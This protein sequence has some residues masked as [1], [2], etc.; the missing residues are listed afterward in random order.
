MKQLVLPVCL[1]VLV[2]SGAA[3]APIA[4]VPP[5]EP[6][7]G[8]ATTNDNDGYSGGR[9]IGFSVSALFEIHSVGVWHDLTNVALSYGL[10]EISALSGTFTKEAALRSGSAVVS[11]SG[12]EWIDFSFAPVQLRPRVNYLIEFSHTAQGNQNFFYGNN[13]QRWSQSVFDD[14]DGTQANSGFLNEVVAAFR[15]NGGTTVIPLPGALLLL[16][17]A[18][19]ALGVLRHGRVAA[20]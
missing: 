2:G 1:G 20:A 5:N 19:A 9:G 18:L 12:L 4:F 7:G 17:S 8:V 15:V 10:Y 13:N 16:A 3:A 14:L 11:T 6:V